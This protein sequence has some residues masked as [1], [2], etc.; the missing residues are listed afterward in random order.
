MV[1]E[2]SKDMV[3]D[4]DPAEVISNLNELELEEPEDGEKNKEFR[5]GKTLYMRGYLKRLLDSWES[6]NEFQHKKI[7]GEQASAKDKHEAMLIVAMNHKDEIIE[8]LEEM[9]LENE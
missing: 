9:E 1:E 6:Y 2:P 4:Y 8:T 5:T 7:F 3:V